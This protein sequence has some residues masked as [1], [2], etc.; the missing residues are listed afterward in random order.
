MRVV[1]FERRILPEWKGGFVIWGAGR[2]GKDFY[3][4][5]TPERREQVVCFLD[6]D[7]NKIERGY[8]EFE[9]IK[10]PIV[11]FSLAVRDGELREK[12][13]GEWKSGTN[14]AVNFGKIRKGRDEP[15]SKST[16]K[17]KLERRD[18]GASLVD[19]ANLATLPAVVCVAMY[20]TNGAL[21]SNVAQIGR[22]EGEDL[23]HFS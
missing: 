9:S 1:A 17:Q 12:L 6:V 3:K 21:E 11:H 20:R 2:D 10:V 22:T 18:P 23:W 4:A 8:Y 13:Y 16:K 14:G 7:D 15:F 5:L 19:P